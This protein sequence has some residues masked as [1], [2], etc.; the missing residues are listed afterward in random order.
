MINKLK[1]FISMASKFDNLEEIKSLRTELLSPIFRLGIFFGGIT[2]LFAMADYL[3]DGFY[4]N[5]LII[6]VLFF[7]F[8]LSYIYNLF[9]DRVKTILILSIFL[10]LGVYLILV[11]G[12]FSTGI[13][14][15]SA[16][17]I[18]TLILLGARESLY[19][20]IFILIYAI[21]TIILFEFNIVIWD[22]G[23]EYYNVYRWGTTISDAVLMAALISFSLSIFLQKLGKTLNEEKKLKELI[24]NELVEKNILIKTLEGKIN[25]IT[26]YEQN[27]LLINQ[28]LGIAQNFGE[29]GLWEY[30]IEEKLFW[31]SDKTLAILEFDSNNHFVENFTFFDKIYADDMDK[32]RE[33]F[34]NQETSN[35][36]FYLKFRINSDEGGI[37]W[38]LAIG[39]KIYD[40]N[41]FGTEYGSI[42]DISFDVTTQEALQKSEFWFQNIFD[43]ALDG[44][45]II[46]DYKF[47]QCNKKLQDIFDLTK[48]ELLGKS[49]WELSPEYQPD[50]LSSETKSKFFLDKLNT[51]YESSFEWTHLKNNYLEFTVE[52]NLRRFDYEGDT[53]AVAILRDI[54]DRKKYENEIKMLNSV[55]ESKVIERTEQLNITLEELKYENEERKR[56]QE[57]LYK[58]QDEL[59]YSLSKARELNQLK[60]KFIEM[61]SHE[62]RTP[63]T[64]IQSASYIIEMLADKEQQKDLLKNLGII[65]ASVGEMTNLL[66][67]IFEIERTD[68]NKY[69]PNISQL[70][71]YSY[72]SSIINETKTSLNF[73]GNINLMSSFQTLVINTDATALR[74]IIG[75]I[76]NNSIKFSKINPSINVE[77]NSYQDTIG[78]TISDNGIG[79]PRN[80]LESIFDMFYKADNYQNKGAGLGLTIVKNYVDILGG[81]I[82]IN[83]EIN[84]GTTVNIMLPKT[85]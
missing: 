44:L 63:L 27:L 65:K 25:E 64:A 83:S 23:F 68:K 1:D 13:L 53:F 19:T 33:K 34:K 8:I 40:K 47:I 29:V 10:F 69:N 22:L 52:V 48:N 78:I 28:R 70:E 26:N 18:M 12:M 59:I 41:G 45:V 67:E 62:Y 77:L 24:E 11:G 31:F 72:I 71:I 42:R 17:P 36:P 20:L 2:Y 4:I 51:D 16:L 85:I 35:E 32:I 75:K 61:A 74:S 60:S 46:K 82:S 3:F 43:N 58:L 56:T 50:G 73:Q 76:L 14:W 55:L 6:S 9:S 80:Q 21:I 15:L 37:K 79:I 49:P 5:A 38:I 84:K 81:Q 7:I 66:D 57:E 30:N 54:S 39:Q